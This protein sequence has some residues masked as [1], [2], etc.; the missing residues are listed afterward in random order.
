MHIINNLSTQIQENVLTPKSK[1][2]YCIIY[3]VGILFLLK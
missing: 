2:L 3:L 1:I